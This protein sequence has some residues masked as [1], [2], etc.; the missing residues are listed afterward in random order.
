MFRTSSSGT[1]AFHHTVF[2]RNINLTF[3]SGDTASQD[4]IN[5][6]KKLAAVV[7]TINALM[8]EYSRGN[9]YTVANIL[10]RKMYNNLSIALANVTV[11]ANK[12]PEYETL[13]LSSTS[14]LGGLFQSIMQ[15]SE[16]I[17]IQA[18]LA[19]AKDHESILYDRVK[20][21]EY[22]NQFNQ[23]RVIFP[24]SNVQV[25]AATLKPEYAEYIKR[26]GF[27]AGAVF[28]PDKLAPILQQLGIK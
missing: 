11:S 20:L 5:M 2:A 26:H 18:Q 25:K 3:G 9:F 14:A 15:Y 23:S 19:I 24:D 16:Y 28:E 22:I 8:L 7:N 10:T 21:Q 17:D 13:R 4:I 6:Y 12:Y 27:P 1:S